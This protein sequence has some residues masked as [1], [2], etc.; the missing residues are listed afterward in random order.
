MRS[1]ELLELPKPLVRR[2]GRRLNR[3][4]VELDTGER[5]YIN[6]TGRLLDVLA[7]GRVCYCLP[8]PAGSTSLRLIAVEDEGGAALIDT[9]LQMLAFERALERGE[10][11][12]A[13]CRVR[14]RNP[15]LGSSRLDYLL[16]CGG[17]LVYAELK[18]AVLRDGGYAAYPDCPSPRGRRH[19]AELAGYAERGGRALIVF[20]AAL[21]RV[22][23][24][25]P[26]E[27]GDPEIPRL[28]RE[29]ARKG[30]VIK[31]LAMH[32]EPSPSTVVLDNP[33]IPV[34]L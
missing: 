1:R 9:Q 25:K 13:P 33:D 24:F 8:K 30:V 27:R 29:A 15:R 34:I 32:Y 2:V 19:I 23:G 18:S 21:P 11:P 16:E 17:E 31:A 3:F 22:E 12:W 10:L 4:V 7:P 6:N 5:A 14:A 20:V 28:L 26:Y